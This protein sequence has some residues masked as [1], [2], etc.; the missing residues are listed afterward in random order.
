MPQPY[1]GA[2]YTL[3]KGTTANATHWTMV[4]KCSG[5]TTYQGGDGEMTTLNGTGVVE[6]AWAQGTSAVTEPANNASTFGV[7]AAFGKW[8]HDL[9]AARNA[10]F[11]ALV[12]ANIL[13]GGVATTTAPSST[14]AT[15]TTLST[16]VKPSGTGSTKIPTSCAGAGNPKFSSVLAT[17]W[18][19]TKILGGLT[20]PRTIVFDSEGNMLVIQNG[21]GVTFHVMSPDGCIT[22]TKT[23]I[24][25]N[26]LNH[27]LELSADGKTLYA[28][29][30]TTVYSWPYTAN[31]ASTSVGTRGQVVTGMYNGGKYCLDIY[32]F[33]M[34]SIQVHFSNYLLTRFHYR[35]PYQ[36]YAS[37]IK[38]KPQFAGRFSWLKRQFRLRGWKQGHRSCDC[39]GF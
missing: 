5:C 14:T 25:L 37:D 15:A 24:S 6:F 23:L 35:L 17:G 16:T 30:S 12:K 11:D 9:N 36:S 28:S 31:G 39:Q 3:L 33:Q 27:G 7:H 4:A 34:P 8:H 29:S 38:S 20:S 26:T 1:D 22:S 19:A 32:H 2:E 21:K 18:K 10:N 13:P